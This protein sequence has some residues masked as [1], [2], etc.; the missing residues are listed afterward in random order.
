[1]RLLRRK[2]A[3]APCASHAGSAG[4]GR[5]TDHPARGA[6]CV[7]TATLGGRGGLV[8]GA[9]VRWSEV[10]PFGHTVVCAAAVWEA[11]AGRRPEL[12]LHEEAIRATVREPDRLYLDW[13]STM[14]RRPG[15]RSPP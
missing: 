8:S 4:H 9:A 3:G 2:A 1:M 10:D 12:A 6:R 13:E 11:K 14:R 15:A 5:P 7:S